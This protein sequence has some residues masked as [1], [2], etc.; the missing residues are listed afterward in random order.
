MGANHLTIFILALLMN[1][2]EVRNSFTCKPYT[3]SVYHQGPFLNDVSLTSR[4]P[5]C[6]GRHR[7]ND[8]WYTQQG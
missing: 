1:F 7:E 8:V 4:K 2:R 3:V 6:D 5:I